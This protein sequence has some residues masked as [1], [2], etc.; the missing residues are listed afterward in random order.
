M[1]LELS[2]HAKRAVLFVVTAS[3]VCGGAVAYAQTS[4]YA[5]TTDTLVGAA[6]NTLGNAVTQLR[7]D[8][9]VLQMSERVARA[10]LTSTGAVT[11]QTGAWL[12]RVDR[13]QTGSYVISF[14]PGVFHAVPTCV[15]MPSARDSAPP[16]LECH[17][18]TTTGMV[19]RAS[20]AGAPADT[21][22]SII[23]AGS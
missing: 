23:C 4:Q 6:L 21:A 16:A 17:D 12:T 19:C 1:K 9:A 2:R 3:L 20:A 13:P 18:V 14:A 11:L 7:A 22:M 8:V 15:T 5:T 10:T